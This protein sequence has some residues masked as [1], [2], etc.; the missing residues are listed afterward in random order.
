VSY[1]VPLSGCEPGLSEVVGGKAIGLGSLIRANLQV[2]PGF[3]IGAHAYREFVSESALGEAIGGLL[4]N[5][6][7]VRAEAEASRQLR[8]LFEERE[9]QA[10]LREAC[11]R[12]YSDLGEPPVAVRSSAVREDAAEASFAG[13]HETCLWIQGAEAVGRAVVRCWA[14]LFTPQALA[15]FRRVGV[16]PEESAMGVVVQAMIPAEC[17]GVMITLDPVTGDRSQITVE[18]SFGLG[19]AVVAGEVTPDR[20]AVDKVLLDIRSR[21]IS[22]KHVARRFDSSAGEVRLV[23]VPADEQRLPC[24][25]DQEVVEVA[26]IGKRVERALGAAQDI[27]WALG[28]ERDVH[29]LQARPETVWSRGRV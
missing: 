2:P 9:L 25:S 26:A 28:P 14:S 11:A 16:R 23:A 22:P 6:D 21:T 7:S 1:I 10:A 27:E 15:Y 4:A 18:A 29:L 20:Y 5:V 8:L 19:Q 24:M 3:A 13:Q 12:A 17:A